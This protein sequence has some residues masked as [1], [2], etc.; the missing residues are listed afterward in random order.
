M[1]THS[2]ILAWEIPWMEEPGSD[3]ATKQK[4]EKRNIYIYICK[5]STY[6]LNPNTFELLSITSFLN[7]KI[8]TGIPASSFA[9][10]VHSLPLQ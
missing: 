4:K 3:L 7:N 8:L 9:P 6:S 10:T 1:A 2:S 5:I